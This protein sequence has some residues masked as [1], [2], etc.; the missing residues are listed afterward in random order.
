MQTANMQFG[1]RYGEIHWKTIKSKLNNKQ[2]KLF[3]AWEKEKKR[4][5]ICIGLWKSMQQRS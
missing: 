3:S 5:R 4:K 1:N 2:S